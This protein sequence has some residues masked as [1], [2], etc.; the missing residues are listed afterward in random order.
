MWYQFR[1][2]EFEVYEQRDCPDFFERIPG[3]TP[4]EHFDYKIQR[5]NLKDTYDIAKRSRVISVIAIVTSVSSFLF[6]LY[7]H[8]M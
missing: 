5:D 8:F 7:T 6:H 1:L 3:V 2:P 4:L